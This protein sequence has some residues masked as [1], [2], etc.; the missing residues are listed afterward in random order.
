M[1]FIHF[2]AYHFCNIVS[3]LNFMKLQGGK[4]VF[5]TWTG[6]EER[7]SCPL[8]ET[9]GAGLGRISD[10]AAEWKA[11]LSSVEPIGVWKSLASGSLL[12]RA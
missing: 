12:G 10:S 3:R 5:L 2:E 11:S 8:K 6:A 4:P 9:A 1:E 7:A